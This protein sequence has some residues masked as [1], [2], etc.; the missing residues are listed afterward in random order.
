MNIS[1][2][3]S[4]IALLSVSAGAAAQVYECTDANG[5]KTYAKECPSTS[6]KEKELDS[7]GVNSPGAAGPSLDDKTR[8]ANEA[9][10]KRRAERQK[11]EAEE[12]RRATDS[13]KAAQACSDAKARLEILESG[14]PARRVDPVTGDHVA[15][16]DIQRQTDIDALNAQ[17]AQY[18]K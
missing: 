16:D 4:L 9:F 6:V 8:E 14:R 7:P 11:Q 5:R 2:L 15:V 12:Q 13:S 1:R 3:L 17:I 10:E 18:C